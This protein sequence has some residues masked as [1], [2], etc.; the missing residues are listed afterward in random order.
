MIHPYKG[1][2]PDRFWSRGVS[3][4]PPFELDP[5][6]QTTFH[7]SKT[8]R[9]VTAGSCFA[10][11]IARHL[12]RSGYCY[13][14]TETRPEGMSETEARDRQ[15][16]LF[17]ARYGNLYTTLQLRQLI[18]EALFGRHS[19]QRR[20]FFSR[21]IG[22][23]SQRLPDWP[24]S[25]G[26]FVDPLRPT[27][28]PNGFASLTE[29]LSDRRRHLAAVKLALEQADVFVFTLGLTEG[30]LHKP[31]NTALPLAPGV[32]G[33]AWNEDYAFFNHG[34][35]EVTR[36]LLSALT[37]I[38]VHNPKCRFILTVSPV[39]LA[40]T[41]A[42]RHVL[43]STVYSKSV[44]R[45]AAQSVS[46]A[47]PGTLYFPSYE[48][49]TAPGMNYYDA[50]LR[51]VSERGVAHVMRVFSERIANSGAPRL[52]LMDQINESVERTKNII[53]DEERLAH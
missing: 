4:I 16:G 23:Q 1:L 3:S 46:D 25:S 14:V 45:V 7:I 29:M 47:L 40:A 6:G 8:D 11:H 20:T 52:D 26:A 12:A 22:S 10:Q 53:C 18:E 50:D 24:L 51:N 32:Y 2:P 44:L 13:H 38:R 34:T 43:Q 28:E 35:E 49:I 30:W 39:P 33:G 21:L 15:Y 36:N 19:D 48:I 37:L 41:Y 9:I 5:L 42:N 31:T 17:S 27:V